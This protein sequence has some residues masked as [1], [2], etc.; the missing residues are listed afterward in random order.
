MKQYIFVILAMVS[1]LFCCNGRVTSTAPKDN[2]NIIKDTVITY[3]LED[4]SSEGTEVVAHYV[5]N[6]ITLCEIGIYGEMGRAKLVYEFSDN[7]IKVTEKDY[8]YQV[9]FMEV[10]EKD[11]KLVKDFSY[12]MDLNGVPLEKVDSS[13]IDIFQEFKQV[14]PFILIN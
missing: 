6:K 3:D 1:L 13:R 9:P 4:I 8:N 12:T 2:I 14:V 5:Q 10:T 7:Q 11:I